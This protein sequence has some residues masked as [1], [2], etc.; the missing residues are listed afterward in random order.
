MGKKKAATN[1][2]PFM[3]QPDV[4]STESSAQRSP[5]ELIEL[6]REAEQLLQK[7]E[8]EY[9]AAKAKEKKAKDAVKAATANQRAQVAFLDLANSITPDKPKRKPT[10]R[11]P[12][13]V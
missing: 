2:E 6:V 8:R 12:A 3:G 10:R 1:S 11:A 5:Q 9:E 4:G 7:A 13:K